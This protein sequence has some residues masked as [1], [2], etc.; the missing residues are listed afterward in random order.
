M[1][2]R[3]KGQRVRV[4]RVRRKSYKVN[5]CICVMKKKTKELIRDWLNALAI[6]A[7][8]VA[9]MILLYGIINSF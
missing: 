2:R 7:G 6:L 5:L 3:R 4:N 8:I 1:V 9:I